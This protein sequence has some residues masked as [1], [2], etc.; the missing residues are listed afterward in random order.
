MADSQDIGSQLANDYVS[1]S[2]DGYRSH[3]A[4]NTGLS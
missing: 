4:A 1:I 2:G 3:N